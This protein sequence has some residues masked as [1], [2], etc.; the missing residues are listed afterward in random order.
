MM[1]NPTTES[2]PCLISRQP[3]VSLAHAS[4]SASSAIIQDNGIAREVTAEIP[5]QDGDGE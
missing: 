1:V 3:E 5:T 4:T 2:S